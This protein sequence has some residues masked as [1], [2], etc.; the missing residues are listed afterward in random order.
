MG[1]NALVGVVAD[2]GDEVRGERIGQPDGFADEVD[3]DEGAVV[4]VGQDGDRLAGE[5]R[6]QVRD[7]D[8]VAGDPDVGG[9]PEPVPGGEAGGPGQPEPGL[10][11]P[12]DER[13]AAYH[14][15]AL[16]TGKR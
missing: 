14:A 7:R 15:V 16:W 11:R 6:G 9:L 3:P 12:A 5:R 13:A 1:V 4:Q 2:Q 8:G 10:D